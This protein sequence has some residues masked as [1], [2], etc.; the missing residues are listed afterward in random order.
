[1]HDS[2]SIL[3]LMS[4][5][6]LDGI[7]L[8]L[9]RFSDGGSTYSII[10]A[11]TLPYSEEWKGFLRST[12]Q[13]SGDELER[14]N[15][16][17]GEFLGNSCNG[18]LSGERVDYIASH[19]HTIFHEPAKGITYQLGSGERIAAVTGIPVVNDFRI[20]DVRL[21]GQGAPLVPIGDRMLFGE[22]QYCLN[23]GGF[24]NVSYEENGKRIAFDIAPVNYVL[25]RIARRLQLEFDEGGKISATGTYIASIGAQLDG[26]PFYA[27]APPK[28][29]GREWVE[30]HVF[31]LLG[32]EHAPADLL[33]TFAVHAAKQ[34]AKVLSGKGK[35]LVTG[36][37]AYNTFFIGELQKNSVA[38]IVVPDAQTVNF[39]EALIF[40]L[41][42][43]LRVH[44][45][46]NALASVT[47][48]S[49]DSCGGTLHQPR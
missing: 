13:A 24:A 16:V 43:Y 2:L 36:G 3:G 30:Q 47:G 7:D 12:E 44:G 40:A 1:M 23:I 29:L 31:P 35:A 6:S 21:G 48:A 22:Y 18:F 27:A 46:V 10:R 5:T 11:V 49:K 9:C 38:E 17:Y 4:G 14:R 32:E 33:H 26:L 37:G 25:N 45:K 19:G 28:S 34:V 20:T 8:A 39:K 41:L 15:R 42:G